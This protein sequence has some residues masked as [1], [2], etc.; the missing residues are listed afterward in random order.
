V[1]VHF[2]GCGDAFGSGGRAQTCIRVTAGAQSVLVDCGATSLAAMRAQGLD[3][4]DIDAVAVTHLHGDHFGGLPFLILDA[5]FARRA[6]PLRVVGPAGTGARLASA[7]E[8]LFPGS[9]RVERRFRVVV[10]EIAPGAVIDIG[11][12]R[13]RCWQV[14]HESGAPPLALRVEDDRS[15]FAYSGDTE[16]TPAL[17]DAADGASL[18]AAEAYTFSRPIR[19]HLD[20]RTL[21]A[22][23]GDITAHRI[24]LT[25]M[26]ADMLGRLSDAEYPAAHDGLTVEV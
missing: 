9:T 11:A 2:V 26:S 23:A 1:Q 21:Q 5:Q 7:M 22:H 4:Q 18:F 10:S 6:V 15:S 8:T 12:M 24:V 13:I 25:H 20:Y 19:Y 16:W 14:V 3:P 17:L